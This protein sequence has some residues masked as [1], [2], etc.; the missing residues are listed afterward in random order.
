MC[1]FE[2][3]LEF[4]RKIRGP[5]ES[6]HNCSYHT[7]TSRLYLSL[8]FAVCSLKGYMPPA[9]LCWVQSF[10]ITSR[11]FTGLYIWSLSSLRLAPGFV[12]R[13]SLMRRT[14]DVLYVTHRPLLFTFTWS[15]FN[16]VPLWKLSNILIIVRL[17]A[18]E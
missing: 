3:N 15:K 6:N 7:H 18:F 1:A 17:V 2:S 5:S 12:S 9:P 4:T 8:I 13:H 14:F 10:L 11:I 16:N